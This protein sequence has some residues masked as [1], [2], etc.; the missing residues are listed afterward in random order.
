MPDV[1]SSPHF[2]VAWMEPLLADEAM[3]GK[4]T[5]FQTHGAQ[6]RTLYPLPFLE[7]VDRAMLDDLGITCQGP[8]PAH[9]PQ[10]INYELNFT[11]TRGA[12]AATDPEVVAGL[13][14]Y[15]LAFNNGKYNLDGQLHIEA[16]K[17]DF[18]GLIVDKSNVVFFLNFNK[19]D[20]ISI[21]P[22]CQFELDTS[23]EEP[24]VV[25]QFIELGALNFSR[26]YDF[27][28]EAYFKLVGLAKGC[29]YLGDVTDPEDQTPDVAF[30][31][32][33]TSLTASL[34][35]VHRLLACSVEYLPD[36]YPTHEP[37]RL[38][39]DA[40]VKD[41]A[42]GRDVVV[43]GPANKKNEKGFVVYVPQ[44]THTV[45]MNPDDAIALA[46][47]DASGQGT[48][49]MFVQQMDAE[50]VPTGKF[51]A[52]VYSLQAY[53]ADHGFH[54]QLPD[55]SYVLA[56]LEN[57]C[58]Y[59]PERGAILSPSGEIVAAIGPQGANTITATGAQQEMTRP[60]PGLVVE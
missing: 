40:I 8:V 25:R 50:G 42:T 4:L 44:G 33:I 46:A 47:S 28:S 27:D 51:A 31:R 57:T 22:L 10:H 26:V 14:R 52:R 16:L 36:R 41:E 3:R 30:M 18:G 45:D 2:D 35:S 48:F 32:D 43:F 59:D 54:V 6:T 21:Q 24:V 56:N 20:K 9:L 53:I 13:T 1:S 37:H 39:V 15:L 12:Y 23:G 55:G 17:E 29:T 11:D 38:F 49:L 34:L 5:P 58:R 19:D 7:H 60:A